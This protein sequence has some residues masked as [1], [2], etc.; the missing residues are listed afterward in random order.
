MRL[1][2]S[3][4]GNKG[5]MF[6]LDAIIAVFIM[7]IVLT[8]AGFFLLRG[9]DQDIT[10]LQLEKIGADT[11]AAMDYQG[12]FDVIVKE[13]LENKIRNVLPENYDMTLQ[14]NCQNKNVLLSSVPVESFRSGER[15]IVTNSLEYCHIKYWVWER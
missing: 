6:T 5:I 11:I 15:I 12:D 10:D 9:L 2:N 4:S 8:A 13:T 7:A 1:W 3:Y 14:L